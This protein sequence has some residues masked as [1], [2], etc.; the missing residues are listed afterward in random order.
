VALVNAKAAPYMNCVGL[1]LAT[2]EVL[3]DKVIVDMK[4]YFNINPADL[5]EPNYLGH[6]DLSETNDC[7][8][9]SLAGT[10]DC[11]Y[12]C[13][14]IIVDQSADLMTFRKY[15][16]M[17]CRQF[18]LL[19]LDEPD[20]KT[21]DYVICHHRVFAY[22]LRSRD[23]GKLTIMEFFLCEF[24]SLPYL[25]QVNVRALEASSE[26]ETNQG[27]D[28]LVLPED[29]KHILQSQVREHFRKRLQGHSGHTEDDMD[30]VKGKGQG[31][32]ILLHGT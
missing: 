29:H 20:A 14:K 22:N 26:T 12:G 11:P 3:N 23:W 6:M 2:E 5:P 21:P 27:F 19:D 17:R 8:S 1:D 28:L 24:V 10:P 32:I 15:K 25:V 30:L 16:E 7:K 18:N 4:E 31:L 9:C 13:T